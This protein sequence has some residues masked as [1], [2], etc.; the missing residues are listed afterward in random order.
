VLG[1]TDNEL[2]AAGANGIMLTRLVLFHFRAGTVVTFKPIHWF[3]YVLR[4]TRW[5]ASQAIKEQLRP[6]YPDPERR[7]SHSYPKGAAREPR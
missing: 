6:E 2:L 3:R 4:Y 5:G 7:P 1:C